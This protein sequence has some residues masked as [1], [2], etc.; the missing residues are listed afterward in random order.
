MSSV[1][2]LGFRAC[3]FTVFGE[4]PHDTVSH[5]HQ[6]RPEVTVSAQHWR[7]CL[8]STSVSRLP[9]SHRVTLSPSHTPLT[10]SESSPCACIGQK[11][12]NL[13]S[14]KQKLI[15]VFLT[16]CGFIPRFDFQ[17]CNFF[18]IFFS[19]SR[20][21]NWSFCSWLAICN[22]SLC[23]DFL[24]LYRQTQR[25]CGKLVALET[26]DYPAAYIGTCCI[27]LLTALT[28]TPLSF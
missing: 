15:S 11:N 24:Q 7:D 20:W 28:L 10:H 23:G 9:F 1:S 19:F 17:T 3:L 16:S 4:W 14:S 2:G 22:I 12:L 21:T 6:H 8:S 27:L 5:I 18:Y 13:L 26:V 25:T